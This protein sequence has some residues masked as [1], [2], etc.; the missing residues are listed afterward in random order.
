MTH[1]L[2]VCVPN[3]YCLC[4][5]VSFG[6]MCGRTVVR[7]SRICCLLTNISCFST[8][9]PCCLSFWPWRYFFFTLNCYL[10]CVYSFIVLFSLF[11]FVVGLNRTVGLSD[12]W[13]APVGFSTTKLVTPLLPVWSVRVVWNNS[14]MLGEMGRQ[15]FVFVACLHHFSFRSCWLIRVSHPWFHPTSLWRFT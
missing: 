12:K 15:W 4:G 3:S 9:D 14:R 2:C 7:D 6:S 10:P 8:L 1:G 13:M 11:Y 5:P